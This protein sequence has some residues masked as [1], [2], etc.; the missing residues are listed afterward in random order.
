ML[1]HV[2]GAPDGSVHVLMLKQLLVMGQVASEMTHM[3][4][5]HCNATW[6]LVTQC[7]TPVAS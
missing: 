3:H 5:Y 2:G 7:T 4:F 1:N 6:I